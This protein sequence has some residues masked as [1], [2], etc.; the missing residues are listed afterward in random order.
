[1]LAVVEVILKEQIP[2]LVVGS[3]SS[4]FYGIPRSTK[5]GDL[6]VELGNKSV[7]TITDQLGPGFH[8][9]PQIAFESVLGTTRHIVDVAGTSFKIELF[10]LSA[11][12][13]DQE[14]FAR[15]VVQEWRGRQIGCRLQRT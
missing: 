2:F 5:D 4:N 7:R 9:D 1:M 10:R 13:H 12:P 15:R 3:F 8:L 14:R 11:D 6:V